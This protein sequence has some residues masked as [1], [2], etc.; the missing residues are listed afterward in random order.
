MAERIYPQNSFNASVLMK[1]RLPASIKPEDLEEYKRR[2]AEIMAQSKADWKG[3]AT[4][5]RI[6]RSAQDGQFDKA[7]MMALR[8]QLGVDPWPRGVD[9][10]EGY[11]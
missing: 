5:D 7:R 6:L 10:F 11:R 3:L 2:M 1:P 4:E 9:L 8:R